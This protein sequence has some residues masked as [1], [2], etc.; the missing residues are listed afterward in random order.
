MRIG[1]II[2]A[3]GSGSRA[4]SLRPKQLVEIGGR[5]MVSWSLDVFVDH[6]AVDAIVLVAPH[7]A[8]ARYEE[9]FPGAD[10]V[11]SGGASRAL[12]VQSGIKALSELDPSPT[13]VLIH[14]AARPGLTTSTIDRLIEAL[15]DLDGVA[16]AIP[17]VDALKRDTPD[18]LANV[19]RNGLWRIQTP[20]GFRLDLIRE[21]LNLAGPDVVDDLEAAEKLG[22]R[23][24]VVRGS[25]RLAK[26]TYPEDFETMG[27]LLSPGL[28]MRIGTGFDVHGLEPGDGVTL[29]GV[30]I[31]H[32]KRLKGH[33]DADVA[34]HA[35]TDAI[36]GALA[37][38]DIGDHFPPSDPRWAGAPSDVFLRKAVELAD[39]HG[40]TIVNCDL[41]LICEAPR[42]KPHREAMRERT[43]A[44]LDI[45]LERISVKA[46]TTE[47][48]GF[49]GR[50]EG[51]AAQA[52]VM[53]CKVVNG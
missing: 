25:E 43:R 26:V 21:A 10:I 45:P 37:L 5:A 8:L 36:L 34:W 46:T 15:A 53:I 48:L 38:G 33:S 11:V 52:A 16:P 23:L 24:G 42:V 3:A 2:L 39:Q 51:I 4:E 18:S 44:V 9:M 22:A 12:S 28:G 50:R 17:V 31:P 19:E 47:G 27:N 41:T 6:P 29:C 7:G 30:Q 1:A 40:F 32:D 35:L 20:Q 13:H 14:D 49:T